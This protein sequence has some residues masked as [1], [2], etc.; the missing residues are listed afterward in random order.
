ML[1]VDYATSDGTATAT[2]DYTSTS[3]TLTFAVGETRKTVSVPIVDDS[4]EDSGE[5]FTLTL[6]NASGASILD[7][8]A[9]GTIL[10]TEEAPA[11]PLTA[12]LKN[13]PADGHDGSTAFTVELKFS[14]AVP[15]SYRRLRDSALTVTNGDVTAAGRII[16][17]ENQRWTIT[18][19]P[20][21]N[22]DVTI[23]LPATTSCTDE[24]A[25][26]IDGRMLSAAVSAT[27]SGPEPET[28]DTALTVSFEAGHAPPDTHDGSTPFSFRI[29]FTLEP[30]G[31]SYRTLRDETMDVRQN[32]QLFNATSVKRLATGSNKRWE[33]TITPRSA[34]PL[35]V[36]IAPTTDCND[37]GAVCDEHGR[38]LSNGLEKVVNGPPPG[39]SVADAQVQEAAGA[40]VDFVVTLDPASAD[41][42]TVD[43]TTS[44]ETGTAGATAGSDYTAADDTL[45]FAPGETSKTIRIA[46]LD[47][48]IDEGEETFTLTLS[49]ASGGAVLTDATATGTIVN[50]DR[51]PQAWLARFGRTVASQAVDA[52][53]ARMEG[54]GETHVTVGGLALPIGNGEAVDE[55]IEQAFTRSLDDEMPGATQSMTGR[56]LLLGSAFQLSSG[57]EG[58][59]AAW[60]AW[61]RVATSG[62]EADVD[63][64]RMDATV[65]SAFLGADVGA[66]RWLAGMAVSLSEGEGDFSLIED[67]DRGEVESTLTAVYPYARLS[68]SDTVDVWGL[69]GFGQGEL[70][71]RLLP[72]ADRMEE[73]TYRP[74]IDMRM[75]AVGV[76]GE[77]LSPSEPGGLTVAVKSDAFWVRTTSERVPGL[78]GSEADVTRMRLALEGSRAFETGG[79]MF[80]PSFEV[81][82]RHD[83]GD[84]ES[85]TGI[86]A[87]AG[88]RYEGAGFSIEGAVHTLIAHEESGYEEWGA[89]GS[90][91]IDPGASGRGLSLTLAPS[92]GATGSG[93]GQLWSLNDAGALTD[94]REFEAGG[95]LDAEVGYGLAGPNHIGVITPFAGM[96]LE[97]AGARGWRTGARWKLSDAASLGLEGTLEE[98]AARRSFG[99]GSSR[100]TGRSPASEPWRSRWNARTSSSPGRSKSGVPCSQ[101]G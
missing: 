81:G 17:G 38:M 48:A 16:T 54:G 99:S 91:R 59:G 61:G 82:V 49:N 85:G 13:L 97:D 2:A 22:D 80:T 64:V 14:E 60:T 86:E 41:T 70:T 6:S 51:M 83:G 5:T 40:S 32:G 67:D 45:T 24:G 94:E 9:T 75:G 87:G 92:W 4:E 101:R 30:E 29:A 88:I 96:R 23:T 65:T 76:R 36:A 46:V 72:D 73:E 93:T 26:C 100:L 27:V 78:M 39:L 55:A 33:V 43:Y 56:E 69:A 58:G 90:V 74:D 21:G 71:L 47:D 42:V 62:F 63:D 10:N 68:V 95:Q 66:E 79:A 8:T 20:D 89:S 19:A 37:A 44:D 18:V 84:A 1:T 98:S 50:T 15:L 25:I 3:A 57:G 12:E 34:G 35:S 28:T 52:I 7:A 11:K 77:V 31:Y 53:G